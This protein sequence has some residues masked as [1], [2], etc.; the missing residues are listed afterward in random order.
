M[1]KSIYEEAAVN[2]MLRGERLKWS[3]QEQ[4]RD[5]PH[6]PLLLN[7]VLQVLAR[8]ITQEK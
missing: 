2:I 1:I 4:D 5:A 6:S 3:F 8:A 7:S